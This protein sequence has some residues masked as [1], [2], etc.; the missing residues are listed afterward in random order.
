VSIAIGGG[1]S[2]VVVSLVLSDNNVGKRRRIKKVA[3]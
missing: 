1:G 3:K 2:G